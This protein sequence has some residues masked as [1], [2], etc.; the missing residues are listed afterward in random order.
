MLAWAAVI[1]LG[2]L[3]AT[4]PSQAQPSL[5]PME[6]LGKH[7]FFDENLSYP[8]GQACS[9]CH[10]PA[11]G[12]T[13][14]NAL[15]NLFGGVQRGAI[16]QRSGNR[17]PPTA[18]YATFTEKFDFTAVSGGVFWDGRATGFFVTQDIFPG[19]WSTAK[20]DEMKVHLTPA[21][22]QAMGPFLNDL[23]QNLP[24]PR[25]LCRRVAASSYSD[26]WEQA[27]DAPLQCNGP[28]AAELAHKRIAF[29]VG[30]Y[31]ASDEFNSFSSWR[32][33]A[34]ALDSDSAFPLDLFTPAQNTGHELFYDSTIGCARFCHSS[35]FRADG[36]DPKE[37]YV[38]DDAGY[39]NIGTPANV[40]NPWYRMSNVYDD[41]GNIINPAGFSWVDLGI[42][43]RSDADFSGEAGKVKV[44]TLRNVDKRPNPLFPKDFAHNGYFKSLESIVD[45]YN[46]RDMKPVCTDAAGSPQRFVP[47]VLAIQRGCW[48]LAE[49]EE[50]V[51]NC[52]DGAHCKVLLGEGETF[53]TYCDNPDND[54]DIGNLCLSAEEE[55]DI[56][57]Y[58]KTLSDLQTPS[59]PTYGPVSGPP[60]RRR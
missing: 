31:E 58:L 1:A 56:V 11:T 53:E 46:T 16:L 41:N 60:G 45:F 18:G 30:V 50:N 6:S 19:T 21:V 12:F 38:K 49:V 55:S 2:S 22:D 4:Q 59:P 47:D 33:I 10:D 26:L 39:F 20:V 29:A 42:A 52:D 36:T 32:D 35:S 7:V 3:L 43:L 37:R 17:R 44:P 28:G 27:W 5:T 8:T 15:T 14:P 51:F 48:P 40:Y 54:R 24:S 25:E 13:S 57:A 34:L 23:E 9:S